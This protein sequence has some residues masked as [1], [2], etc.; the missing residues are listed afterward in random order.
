VDD[1]RISNKD[2]AE[3]VGIAQSTCLAR[4]RALRESGVIRGYHADIDPRALGHDLQAMIAVRLQPT[5]RSAI[6]EF[7]AH[8]KENE[9]GTRL[10]ISLQDPR[11]RTRFLHVMVFKDKAAERRHRTSAAVKQFTRALYPESVELPEFV[12]LRLITST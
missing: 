7:V 10:Y 2:L 6:R 3:R 5:A 8:V 4:V 12:D 9:P 1:A 11:D